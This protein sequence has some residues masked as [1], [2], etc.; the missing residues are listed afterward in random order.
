MR[1]ISVRA[2]GHDEVAVV[3]D[4]VVEAAVRVG[5]V[6]AE[7]AGDER[8]REVRADHRHVP[9]AAQGLVAVEVGAADTRRGLGLEPVAEGADERGVLGHP[10]VLAARGG[11]EETRVL[12]GGEHD[13]LGAEA[14]RLVL[15]LAR[16]R[17]QQALVAAAQAPA[18]G[19][20]LE[21]RDGA[22]LRA[23]ADRDGGGRRG[24]VGGQRARAP[25]VPALA[26]RGA[27]RQRSREVRVA[28]DAL[29][30]Q[31]GS[32]ALDLGGDGVE[33]A[34]AR[35]RGAALLDQRHVEL[36]HVRGE[37]RHQCQRALVDADVVERDAPA[38]LAQPGDRGEHLG[39]PGG[40]RPLGEL[41][42]HAQAVGLGAQQRL[43]PDRGRLDVEEEGVRRAQ[44]GGEGA[45]GHGGAGGAVELREHPGGGGVAE[46][47][48]GRFQ[49]RA[50]RPARERLVGDVCV[51]VSRSTIGWYTARSPP[52][53]STRRR[54]PACP[55]AVIDVMSSSIG[56]QPVGLRPP[57]ETGR[58]GARLQRWL[59][60]EI[61]QEQGFR[62]VERR[63]PNLRAS[64]CGE[65][66]NRMR[67]N[68][69]VGANHRQVAA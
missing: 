22:R 61:L 32:R 53:A 15:E 60:Q 25:E 59:L 27:D 36:D 21:W 18:V 30:E 13:G 6:V 67:P 63:P 33:H 26:E 57:S 3:G 46:Q 16:E 5:A 51:C 7:V 54:P 66:G 4:E 10:L 19:D 20:Q 14:H 28:L 39:G 17:E 12:E 45:L 23:C 24:K 68:R 44:A 40:Q 31:R 64:G 11:R 43:S 47:R 48:G 1:A 34:G 2:G 62:L 8:A 35:P 65:R 37:K 42:H 69:V 52:E 58:A 9:L 56:V 49:R 50:L 29:G 38:A 55:A 41:D